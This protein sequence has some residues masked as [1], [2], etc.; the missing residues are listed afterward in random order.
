MEQWNIPSLD[1]E[2]WRD[3]PGYEWRYMVSNIWRVKSII[4]NKILK[5][6]N[7]GS[8]PTVDLCIRRELVHRL[9]A[10][11]FIPNPNNKPQVNHINGIKY[12]NRLDNLE[13]VTRSENTIHAYRVLWVVPPWLWKKWYNNPFSKT[14]YQYSKDWTFIKEYGWHKQAWRET[15]INQTH[16]T[17]CCNWKRKS[18]WW[19]KWINK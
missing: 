12:D 19:F 14:V 4:R 13:W 17:E 2:E 16:I 18:A 5:L 3:I 9:V 1:W 10:L 15:W 8:Y 11:S 7:S 6:D